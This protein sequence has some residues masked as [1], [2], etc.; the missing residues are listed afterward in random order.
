MR[1]L[2]FSI[3]LMVIFYGC[4]KEPDVDRVVN[5]KY[6]DGK[7]EIICDPISKEEFDA[8]FQPGWYCS[9]MYDVNK[10]G[11]LGP[12]Y[13]ESY[14]LSIGGSLGPARFSVYTENRMKTYFWWEDIE[15]DYFMYSYIP[16]TYDGSTNTLCFHGA[17]YAYSVGDKYYYELDKGIVTTLNESHMDLVAELD[18]HHSISEDA[19]YT[20]YR[21]KRLS[22]TTVEKLD[23]TYRVPHPSLK[24]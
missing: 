3:I 11:S 13:K 10:D 15:A 20:L 9:E 17:F 6:V 23:S 14:G 7:Y 4:S 8:G 2:L 12:G 19:V 16:Y 1:N 18:E 5:L 24:E 21:F 22:K